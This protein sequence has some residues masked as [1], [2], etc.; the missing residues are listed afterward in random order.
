M[1][2]V[3]RGEVRRLDRIAE[4]LYAEYRKAYWASYEYDDAEHNAEAVRL[5]KLFNE[6][7]SRL[8][9][10]TKEREAWKKARAERAEKQRCEDAY[11][12]GL[13]NALIA[14]GSKRR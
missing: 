14:T 5:G 11:Y 13:E 6:V 12:E 7:M 8:E 3:T 4:R 10:A 9:K 1:I 2:T